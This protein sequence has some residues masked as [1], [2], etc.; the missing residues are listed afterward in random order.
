MLNDDKQEKTIKLL[1]LFHSES[2]PIYRWTILSLLLPLTFLFFSSFPIHKIG[3][4]HI[5]NLSI[6]KPYHFFNSLNSLSDTHILP[7][8]DTIDP[9][10][11]LNF[12]HKQYPDMGKQIFLS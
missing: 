1:K 3:F 9:L 12:D 11:D 8:L 7:D 10:A 4:D 5:D 2:V 6:L